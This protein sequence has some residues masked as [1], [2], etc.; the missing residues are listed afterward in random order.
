MKLYHDHFQNYKRYNI[1]TEDEFYE[2][3]RFIE[4]ADCMLVKTKEV[5]SDE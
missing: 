2:L 4:A 1:P 3:K 5:V